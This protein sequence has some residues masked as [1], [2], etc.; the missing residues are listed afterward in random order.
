MENN[1]SIIEL[2]FP[3]LYIGIMSGLMPD[4]TLSHEIKVITDA[5]LILKKYEGVFTM[6]ERQAI[7]KLYMI[8]PTYVKNKVEQDTNFEKI[9]HKAN[10]IINFACDSLKSHGCSVAGNTSDSIYVKNITQEQLIAVNHAIIDL[11][12]KSICLINTQWN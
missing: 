8:L 5:Q 10:E 1:N 9:K 2:K 7:E 4:N 3:R 6:L 12:G 11:Y